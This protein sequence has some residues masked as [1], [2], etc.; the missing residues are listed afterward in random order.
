MCLL[1]DIGDT[2]APHNHGELAATVL[3]PFLAPDLIWIT[4]HQP[5][6]QFSYYG[7]RVGVDPN[8]GDHYREHE[9]FDAT[10]EFCERYDEKCF[11]SAYSSL[12]LQEFEP[13]V[14]KVLAQPRAEWRGDLA[15]D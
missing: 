8:L 6:F 14:R 15:G 7:A 10:V 9:Y 11:D 3:E 1:H 12:P 13:V 4:R 2:L 5:V